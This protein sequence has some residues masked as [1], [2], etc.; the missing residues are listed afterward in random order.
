M[1]EVESILPPDVQRSFCRDISKE[2]RR[3]VC[4]EQLAPRLLWRWQT[5][6]PPS[7]MSVSER[8]PILLKGRVCVVGARPQGTTPTPPPPLTLSENAWDRRV[9]LKRTRYV[10][11]PSL[12]TVGCPDRQGLSVFLACVCVVANASIPC[13][14]PAGESAA[15]GR[16]FPRRDTN[17]V[18]LFRGSRMD[19][20]ADRR[21]G[22]RKRARQGSWDEP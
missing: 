7:R 10:R 18:F 13:V 6:G 14:L 3:Q 22:A 21:A 1:V 4:P 16:L 11:R 17:S 9:S 19:L 8:L 12:S 2:L 15:R 5:P 20:D